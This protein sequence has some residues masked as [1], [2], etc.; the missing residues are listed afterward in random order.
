ML[1]S[2]SSLT[3]AE[4]TSELP[5]L[6][7]NQIPSSRLPRIRLVA[8]E[9]WWE[10]LSLSI[11]LA[12]GQSELSPSPPP[13]TKSWQ[14]IIKQRAR[15]EAALPRPGPESSLFFFSPPISF[16]LHVVRASGWGLRD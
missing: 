10:E 12:L 11:S 6:L 9:I 14:A 15:S 4:W 13:P 5:G 2:P 8:A 16:E 1:G 3:P 7:R